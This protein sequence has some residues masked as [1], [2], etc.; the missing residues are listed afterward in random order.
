MERNIKLV[1]CYKKYW[2][3]IRKLRLDPKNINGFIQTSAITTKEQK[4][5]MTKNSQY[6]RVCLLNDIPVGFIG[7]IDN[8]IRL[9]VSD[10]Y[11]KQGIGKFMLQ[12]SMKIWP[13]AVGKIKTKNI[14]SQKLFES[15][16]F[17]LKYLIYEYD[18]K[19]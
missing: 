4:S 9:C 19:I 1:K 8:D 2:E 12:E 6:Y 11:K 15:C 3:F 17:K 13:H 5:Y 7:V 16:E 18:N 14:A 10:E